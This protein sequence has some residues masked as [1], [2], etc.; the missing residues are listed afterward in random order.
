MPSPRLRP[1]KVGIVLPQ[2]EDGFAGQTP[3]WLNPGF[4]LSERN[5]L[6]AR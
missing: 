1:L 2:V 3:L 4:P 6:H 5:R